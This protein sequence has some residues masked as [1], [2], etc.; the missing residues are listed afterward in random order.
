MFQT[1]KRG[2]KIKKIKQMNISIKRNSETLCYSCGPE[3]QQNMPLQNM[4]LRDILSSRHLKHSKPGRNFIWVPHIC[5]KTE[6]PKETQFLPESFINQGRLTLVTGEKTR[7]PHHTQ[8][9]FSQTIILPTYSS[10]TSLFPKKSF[11]LLRALHLPSPFPSK[12]V[13][14]PEF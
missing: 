1:I 6:P 12:I 4:S 11:P 8:T 14:N 9:N 5:L 7:S 13:F 10:K 2:I 3:E